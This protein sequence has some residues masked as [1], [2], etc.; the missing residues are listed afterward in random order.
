MIWE[1]SDP[2]LYLRTTP[3]GRVIRGGEDEE[4]SDDRQ[5]DVLLSQRPGI[6]EGPN[7]PCLNRKS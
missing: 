7:G 3:D 2:Y 6:S 4:F 1:A 5:R